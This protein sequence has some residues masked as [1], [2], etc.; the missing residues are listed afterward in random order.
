MPGNVNH[1]NIIKNENENLEAF[2]KASKHQSS[3]YSMCLK[4]III[5]N[6]LSSPFALIKICLLSLQ[7]FLRLRTSLLPFPLIKA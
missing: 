3:N 4:Y 2:K 6:L 5:F 7:V 1:K